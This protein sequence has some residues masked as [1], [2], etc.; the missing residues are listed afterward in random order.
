MRYR[1]ILVLLIVIA[2]SMG[3]IVHPGPVQSEPQYASPAAEEIIAKMIAAHGGLEKW[4]ACPTVCFDTYLKVDFG[5]GNWV[6]FW[7][8]VTVEQGT[9][10][11]Y[12]ELPNPDGTSGTIGFD[13]KTA[14][15]AG[16]RQGMAMAPPRFTAWRDFYLF[17]I[18]WLT[19][20]SGVIL[21][22]PG[23]AQIPNDPKEYI[24]IPMNFETGTGDT[25]KDA[26][27]LYIDPDTYRLKASEYGMTFKSM[28]P[29]GVESAPPS[30]FV[31][32]A[33]TEVDG[34][35][36]LTQYN[37][38]WKDGSLVT[39]GEVSNWSFSNPFDES[40]L[41]MPSDGSPDESQPH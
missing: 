2:V 15:G 28:L 14:W 25:S 33:T 27:L 18:P 7:E 5:G 38:Y 23:K 39:V 24:T 10:R 34:L 17:N 19:Q 35:V 16:N 9:R 30:V 12:A 11:V 26:Y 4:N 1:G 32:E 13:G 36:V 22:E 31:W 41:E 37:V 20:D 3:W 21:G 6:E 8:K 40:R 29:E